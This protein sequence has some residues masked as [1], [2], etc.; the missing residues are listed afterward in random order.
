MAEGQRENARG[1]MSKRTGPVR[2]PRPGQVYWTDGHQVLPLDEPTVR[3]WLERGVS[4]G[5][6][7]FADDALQALE[8][9]QRL[10]IQVGHGPLGRI[11]NGWHG[12]G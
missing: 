8:I 6:V 5:W 12:G 4:R 11:A 3:A 1:A 2:P 10:K 7:V 9:G